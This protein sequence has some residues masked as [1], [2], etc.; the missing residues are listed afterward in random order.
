M[1]GR[2]D[3]GEPRVGDGYELLA[4]A[5]VVIG[6]TPLSG[7]KGSAIGTFIGV[8]VL[9]VISNIL[10]LLG[11]HPYPQMIFNALI[12]LGAIVMRGYFSRQEI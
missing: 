7:G 1:E 3:S 5:A 8:L 4:I 11:I 2:L 10:N 12:L 6:G 9:G